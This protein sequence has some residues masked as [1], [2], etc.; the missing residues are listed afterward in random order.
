MDG[1]GHFTHYITNPVGAD[2][3][4]G[5]H[6]INNAI[7]TGVV[8]NP[9]V[10]DIDCN[11]FNIN[12]ALNLVTYTVAN[13]IDMNGKDFTNCYEGKIEHMHVDDLVPYTTT[14]STISIGAELLMGGN[15]I[16][17]IGEIMCDD[18]TATN[19]ISLAGTLTCNAISANDITIASSG[20]ITCDT[21][22]AGTSISCVGD[23]D[24]DNVNTNTSITTP[25]LKL[26]A[27]CSLYETNGM[28]CY[29][30]SIGQHCVAG[31][32]SMFNID[33]NTTT[34]I[35]L[36]TDTY[37][38]VKWNITDWQP[39]VK[40]LLSHSASTNYW[41]CTM[42]LETKD[43]SNTITDDVDL[44]Q[45]SWCY[46]YKDQNTVNPDFTVDD[47][48][49]NIG[50]GNRYYISMV[51]EKEDIAEPGYFFQITVANRN[52]WIMFSMKRI[53]PP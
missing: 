49:T 7:I 18:V 6:Q 30:N 32:D 17:G 38:S 13:D 34:D 15:D 29:E 10:Q 42:T 40:Y 22:N 31:G 45:G 36:Y 8:Q 33:N 28:L 2:I 46:F 25:E 37:I 39:Q 11:G 27:N 21:I 53:L 26:N 12:N 3:D 14:S 48:N 43:V 16:T 44:Q 52:A 20:S 35:I 41:D 4:V 24:A 23:I 9:L 1:T 19:D 5:G 50:W 47:H 51:R